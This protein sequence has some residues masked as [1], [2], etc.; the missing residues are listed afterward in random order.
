ML[1]EVWVVQLVVVWSVGGHAEAGVHPSVGDVWAHG[2][3]LDEATDHGKVWVELSDWDAGLVH[4]VPGLSHQG[5]DG[6]EH[7]VVLVGAHL[8]GTVGEGGV[9]EVSGLEH[10]VENDVAHREVRVHLHGRLESEHGLWCSIVF[11]HSEELNV[12]HGLWTSDND[13]VLHR[14]RDHIVLVSWINCESEVALISANILELWKNHEEVFVHGWRSQ[15]NTLVVIGS[16]GHQG[17]EHG[18]VDPE[19]LSMS[20]LD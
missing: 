4:L 15:L 11:S 19:L 5:A 12:E 9:P 1:R 14:E 10:W 3:V 13:A 18:F 17:V 6:V 2:R 8:H 20:V 16:A 7:E